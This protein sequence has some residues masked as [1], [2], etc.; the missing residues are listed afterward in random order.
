M[1][2]ISTKIK[3]VCCRSTA[4]A[5]GFVALLL[6]GLQ[7]GFA[8]NAAGDAEFLESGFRQMYNLDFPAAH[9]TFETWQELH[10]QDPLGAASNA[11]VYLFAEFDRLHI[12]EFDLFTENRPLDDRDKVPPDPK[13][14]IAF[15]GE[16]AKADA[17]ATALLALSPDD[18]NALFA[19]TLTDGLR[20]NYAALVEKRKLAALD[21]LKSSRSNAEKLIAIDP[22]YHD[23]YLAVG[24]ENYVLGLRSAPTRWMLRLSGAQ[25]SKD[26]GIANLKITAEKG[27]YLAPYARLLLTIAYLRENDRETATKLLAA[28]ARDFP[29]N[30]LY[31]SELA[32]LQS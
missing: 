7:S 2:P 15:E 10:P 20:G 11:A 30:R 19:R 9:K 21:F 6:I 14:I 25:T 28:L 13:F 17:I 31:Q 23:A 4:P 24:I 16:L 3:N 1:F 5:F 27:R 18:C 22:T 8:A 26:K 29:R 12:L 32:R